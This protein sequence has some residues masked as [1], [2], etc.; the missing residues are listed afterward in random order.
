[1][2]TAAEVGEGTLRIGGNRAVLEV[3]V[4]MLA[5]VLLT[6]GLEFLQGIGFLASSFILASILGKS[7]SEMAVPSGGMTS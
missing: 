1:M 7:F 6:V 2:R 3:L 4:N 5:L